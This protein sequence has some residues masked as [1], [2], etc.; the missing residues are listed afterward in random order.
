MLNDD[1]IRL[2]NKISEIEGLNTLLTQQAELRLNG[3]AK[4]PGSLGKLEKLAIQLAGITGQ[5]YNDLKK[6]AV[7]IM[8]SDNGIVEEGVAA[9]PQ[10]VT[11]HQTI[12]FTRGLTGVSV[13]AKQFNSDLM[14]VDVG[15]NA[16]LSHPDI[17]NRKIRKCTHN[18]CK[19]AA[20]TREEAVKAVLIGIEM[21][22]LAHEKGYQILGVGEMGIGN[23]TTSSSILSALTG[24]DVEATVGKGAGLTEEAF[25]KKKEVVRTALSKYQPDPDDPIDVLSKVGGFDIAAMAGVFLGAALLKIPVVIDGFISAVAA[26]VAQKLAPKARDYMIASHASYEKG[27][28]L[29]IKALEL[30]PGLLLDMRLGEGSGCPIMFMIADAACAVIRDMGTFEEAKIDDDYI[31]SITGDQFFTVL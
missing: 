19:Q 16:D 31:Q 11:L 1:E 9:T 12:N 18:F 20:M 8:C 25:K 29:A 21:A 14:V 24:A 15:V 3:L 6:R 30:E 17:I 27:Y 7:I 5:L 28:A 26:L 23:T 2:R 10:S 4:P 22:E 13:I